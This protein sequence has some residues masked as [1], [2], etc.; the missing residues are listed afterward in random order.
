ME[1]LHS[2]ENTLVLADEER[3][4]AIRAL[5]HA[6]PAFG[7]HCIRLEGE[8]ADSDQLV[9]TMDQEGFTRVLFLNPYGNVQRC[10]LYKGIRAAGRR[11]VA[12]HRG[13][14]PDSWC[15]DPRGFHDFCERQVSGGGMDRKWMPDFVRVVD[16]FEFTQTQKILVRSLKRV[17]FDRRRLPDAELYWRE[18]AD[19]AYR[20][21]T[22]EDFDRLRVAFE[23]SERADLLD[24]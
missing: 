13:G 12:W 9:R 10:S 17:H 24:R 6:F 2:S 22:R 20:V 19:R 1:D 5:R 21:F 4:T 8:F 14:L 3:A 18:R 11:P 23:A 16:D 7:R 15:F